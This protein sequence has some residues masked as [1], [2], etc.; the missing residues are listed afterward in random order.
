MKNVRN[1][2]LMALI[3]MGTTPLWAQGLKDA[4]KNYFMIGVAVNQRNVTN[5]EQS[6]LVKKS[7]IV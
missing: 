6:A 1:I 4:Y 3:M 5:A 2:A 7:L